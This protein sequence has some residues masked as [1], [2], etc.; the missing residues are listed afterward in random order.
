MNNKYQRQWE[1]L[2]K[3]DPYWAVLTNKDKKGGKW[4]KKEFFDSGFEEINSILLTVKDLNISINSDVALDFGC[5]VGRLTR[6]LAKKFNKVIAID[7]SRSMIDEAINANRDIDNIKF[8]HNVIGDLNIIESNTIDFIYSNIVLQHIP[9]KIQ[10]RYIEEF[11]RILKIGGVLVFQTP[12]QCDLTRIN[13]LVHYIFGNKILNIVRRLRYGKDCVMEIHTL[14]R[15]KVISILNKN[16]MD[17]VE[18]RR[19]DSSGPA[20]VSFMYFAVKS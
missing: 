4:D 5:G 18:I 16:K 1:Q 13:G 19:H 6:P 3:N 15:K 10:A 17:I 11:C 7:I 8:I 9:P 20:F 2:G 14:H 12:S